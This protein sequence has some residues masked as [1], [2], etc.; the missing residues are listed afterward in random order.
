MVTTT[1]PRVH[2]GRPADPRSFAAYCRHRPAPLDGVERALLRLAWVHGRLRHRSRKQ[3]A[4]R[5]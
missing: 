1:A 5:G 2:A 4:P 3:A